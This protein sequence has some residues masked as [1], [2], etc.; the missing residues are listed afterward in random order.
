MKILFAS[1][2][3]TLPW[4]G[5]P[6]AVAGQVCTR[7]QLNGHNIYPDER[8]V[9]N[10]TID[11]HIKHLRGKIALSGANSELIHSVY[12]VGYKFGL[13]EDQSLPRT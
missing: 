11:S 7:Q 6:A 2:H 8:V 13:R 12:G 10:Q 1:Q 4:P 5:L 3:R 9:A